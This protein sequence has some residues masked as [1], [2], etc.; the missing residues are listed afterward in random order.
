MILDNISEEKKKLIISNK[1]KE[2]LRLTNNYYLLR[3]VDFLTYEEIRKCY[4]TILNNYRERPFYL[5]K[6]MEIGLLKFK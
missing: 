2:L 3:I 4:M 1:L 5:K 6:N